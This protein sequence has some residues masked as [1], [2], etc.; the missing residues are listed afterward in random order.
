MND[1]TRPIADFTDAELWTLR[2]ALQER[3][4]H[5]PDLQLG[6]AEVRLNRQH[7]HLTVCPVAGWQDGDCTMLV[8]K[9][10]PGDYRGEFFYRVHEHYGTGIESF[11]NLAVCL[12]TLL[13]VQ[14]DHARDRQQKSDTEPQD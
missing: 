7:R 13:Q 12:V 14:A 11:D 4:G 8:F 1:A 10:G 6:E 3:Y 5:K 9:S 2:T